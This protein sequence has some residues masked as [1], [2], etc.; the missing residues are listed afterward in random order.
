MISELAAAFK[1][2]N[3]S[4]PEFKVAEFRPRTTRYAVLIPVINEGERIRAQL[5]RMHALSLTALADTIVVDG[6][7]TDGSLA[8]EFLRSVGLRA[9]RHQVGTRSA[10]G[11]I[12]LRLRLGLC[13]QA[14]RG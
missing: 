10:I 6:G 14:M 13:W 11:A 7:S 9:L 5:R 8:E 3:W 4:V 12:T 1:D 2:R